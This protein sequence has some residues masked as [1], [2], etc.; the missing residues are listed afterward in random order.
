[1]VTQKIGY[2][3]VQNS[4]E[5][6]EVGRIL[7]QSF[8]VPDKFWEPWSGIVGQE[9]L[10]VIRTGGA[11]A[12][13]L[14]LYKTGQWFGG[15]SV[16]M[17]GIGAVGVAPHLRGRGIATRMMQE[18]LQE[19]RSLGIP[20]STLYPASVALYRS[21]GYELAGLRV[22][23]AIRTASIETLDRNPMIQPV[24]STSIEPMEGIARQRGRYSPGQLDRSPTLWK[25]L[26]FTVEDPIYS[27]LIG[28]QKKPDGYVIFQ[29]KTAESGYDLHVR[30]M[31]ALSPATGRALWTFLARHSAQSKSIFW[32]GGAVEPLVWHLP[33]P[34]LRVAHSEG[35]MLRIVDVAGALD[36]R[37][38]PAN[39]NTELHLEI[40]DDL[41]SDNSG[42]YVLEVSGGRGKTK[43]GGQGDLLLDIRALAPLY[44]G[45]L[46]PRHLLSLGSIK[47]SDEAIATAE[48]TFSGPQPSMADGF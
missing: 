21:V 43:R 27:Y 48:Q 25:L 17:G 11:V 30:D 29:Q 16:P 40:S 46:S 10:R 23:S 14:V 19:V 8:S 28:P 41:F 2:D 45:L 5:L 47:G 26:C 34:D 35:W 42:R 37:G 3:F 13:A 12:G 9:N 4:G 24:E 1:M 7:G 31:V 20:L 15:R 44:T 18:V 6:E 33:E 36:G 22:R 38:Y 39:L 32:P